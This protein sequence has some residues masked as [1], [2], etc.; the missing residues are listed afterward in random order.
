[1]T[2]AEEKVA[3]AEENL[4]KMKQ[5]ADAGERATRSAYCDPWISCFG[6]VDACAAG[7]TKHRPLDSTQAVGQHL[8]SFGQ[9]D[10]SRG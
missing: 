8:T 3:E 6:A 2:K 10:D 4:Q 7:A 1:M 9:E 5:I